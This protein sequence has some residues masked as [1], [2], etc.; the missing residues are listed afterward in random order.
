[1]KYDFLDPAALARLGAIPVEARQA[2][3]GNVA[4]RHRSPHRGSSVEF[5]EYRKY[6]QGDDTRRLDWKAYARS[7]RY[8]IKEFEADTNLR[9][10]FV[11]DA[12]GS[13]GFSAT[14]D[15]RIQFARKLAATLSYLIVDQGDAAGLSICQE[16]IH[17]EIPPTRRAAHL[18]HIF[19]SL[20]KTEPSG[21]TGLIEALHTI[22]E[23][24]G[25]RALVIIMSDLFCDTNALGDALQHLRYRK[26]DIAVFHM[27][28]KQEIEFDFERPH[29]FVDM[30]DKTTVVAEPVL[31]AEDY[32]QAMRNFMQTVR[33]NC[34][35]VH[36]D[37]HL[38][39][40]DQNYEEIVHNFL[41]TRLP[42]KA[43]K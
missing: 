25:Q 43:R 35:D 21:E 16:K 19:E 4:G 34:H 8:Y 14:H 27:L 10:Y 26:H 24:I 29:R 1:M 20:A 11:L 31:I 41:T 30:E 18:N 42:K 12:S 5:A 40:T 7:D 3:T 36:A 23:K 15:A 33:M 28:D 2:M 37:Y 22:A 9:A 17:L 39:T 13:M 38:I 6:V 32:R